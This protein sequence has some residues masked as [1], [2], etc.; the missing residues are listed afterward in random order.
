TSARLTLRVLR[1]Q[2]AQ[3]RQRLT[4]SGERLTLSARSLLRGRRDRYARLDARLRTSRLANALAQR[5][6][7]AR[8][9]ERTERLAERA[10]RALLTALKRLE[11]RIIHRGQLLAALSYRGALA[12]GFALVRDAQGQPLHAAA[13]VEPGAHVS[14]ESAD[15]R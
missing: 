3:A 1:G 10:H 11:A 12:R 2:V 9:R 6:R 15:G 5:Q 14:I 7:I 4:V 13:N 8:E